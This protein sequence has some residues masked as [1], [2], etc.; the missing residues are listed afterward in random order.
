MAPLSN[1]R[2]TLYNTPK[3]L[4]KGDGQKRVHP[5]GF[6]P[7]KGT[8]LWFWAKKGDLPHFK[9]CTTYVNCCVSL[10]GPKPRGAPFFF[11][12]CWTV[13]FCHWIVPFFGQKHIVFFCEPPKLS[14][15]KYFSRNFFH[16]LKFHSPM[17]FFGPKP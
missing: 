14:I 15:Q 17:S 12:S 16:F 8:P 2:W 1:G 7:K 3:Y 9:F 6:G 11:Y 13:P 10:F 5:Y 4:K